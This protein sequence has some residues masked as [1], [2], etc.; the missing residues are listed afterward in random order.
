MMPKWAWASA[1]QVDDKIL[2]RRFAS[3]PSGF[4]IEHGDPI[5][6]PK[7]AASAQ[8]GEIVRRALNNFGALVKNPDSKDWKFGQ[9]QLL[10]AAQCRSLRDFH[11]RVHN[12]GVRFINDEFILLPSLRSQKGYGEGIAPIHLQSDATDERLGQA[13]LKAFSLCRDA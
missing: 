10:K 6:V 11:N 3:T 7:N 8:I 4:P 12:V 5:E 13:L 9:K 2:V 1:Y